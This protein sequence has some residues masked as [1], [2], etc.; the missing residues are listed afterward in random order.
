MCLVNAKIK[1][2]VFAY[3]STGMTV[4]G[5]RPKR[6]SELLCTTAEQYEEMELDRWGRVARGG[7]KKD[8]GFFHVGWFFFLVYE[9]ERRKNMLMSNLQA[10]LTWYGVEYSNE[11]T[12][13]EL[14]DLLSKAMST[15]PPPGLPEAIYVKE[16]EMRQL[17]L[18][19]SFQRQQ[20]YV[21]LFVY[22]T[23]ITIFFICDDIRMAEQLI[24]QGQTVQTSEL[25]ARLT[26]AT[27][28]TD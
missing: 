23:F 17:Y 14:E 24:R 8:K 4:M 28:L 9:K 10:H 11:N 6:P 26:G 15:R 3:S 19:T 2:G 18:A 22:S 27:S 12:R 20:E 1:D 25:L 7:W 21:S 5:R 13:D 16:A